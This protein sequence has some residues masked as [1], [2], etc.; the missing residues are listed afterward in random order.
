MENFGKVSCIIT[1]GDNF[2][3]LKDAII[4]LLSQTYSNLEIIIVNDGDLAE[5][6]NIIYKIQSKKIKLFNS[7]KIGRGKSLN[8][9]LKNSTGNFICILDSDDLAHC[10]RIEKQINFLNKGYDIVSTNFTTEIDLFSNLNLIDEVTNY[11]VINKKQF[12]FR[13]PICHSSVLISKSIFNNFLYNEDRINLFDYDLWITLKIN[14]K[15]FVK[16]KQILTYKRIHKSQLFENK[17]RLY[18]I[19]STFLLK[20]RAYKHFKENYSDLFILLLTTVY[21]LIPQKFRS[22]FMGKV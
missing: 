18:Y 2:H 3:Y 10:Q 9:G 15:K 5:V 7:P 1:V 4:S 19:Y 21:S 11:D 16:L 20:L 12:I 13:N 14:N 22:I 17:K 6:K 8:L